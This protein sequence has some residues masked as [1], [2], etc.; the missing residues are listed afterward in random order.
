MWKR[1]KPFWGNLSGKYV[2]PAIQE[3]ALAL[4]KAKPLWRILACGP[5]PETAPTLLMRSISGGLLVQQE[6]LENRALTELSAVT[7]A[8]PLRRNGRI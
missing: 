7:I 8:N 6:D 3:E 1:P 4:F 2:C 5:R